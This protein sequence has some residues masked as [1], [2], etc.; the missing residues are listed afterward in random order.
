M[1]T[2]ARTRAENLFKAIT[3]PA[4]DAS[5]SQSAADASVRPRKDGPNTLHLPSGTDPD[6][7]D[8]SNKRPRTAKAPRARGAAR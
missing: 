3:K 1:T 7:S 5:K 8:W 2:L 4:I 6:R